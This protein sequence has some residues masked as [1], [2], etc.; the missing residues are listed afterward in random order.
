[1]ASRPKLGY[2]EETE[3]RN[4]LDDLRQQFEA[5]LTDTDEVIARLER[6]MSSKLR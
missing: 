1:V 6:V 2:F 3:F 4:R 5:V